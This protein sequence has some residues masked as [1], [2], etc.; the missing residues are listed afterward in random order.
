MI[1][2]FLQK[3]SPKYQSST[4]SGIPASC[5]KVFL[6]GDAGER[7]CPVGHLTIEKAVAGG[8]MKPPFS[9]RI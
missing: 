3:F 6:L 8:E 2:Q 5:L 7:A 1:L 4:R 9:S